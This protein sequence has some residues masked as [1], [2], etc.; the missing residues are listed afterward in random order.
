[1][2]GHLLSCWKTQV[3][4]VVGGW[5]VFHDPSKVLPKFTPNFTIFSRKMKAQTIGIPGTE[6]EPH[7]K[8]VDVK[9]QFFCLQIFVFHSNYNF[10][11]ILEPKNQLKQENIF[12]NGG[13][14]K[15]KKLWALFWFF[16]RNFFFRS[17]IT[18]KLEEIERIW[19][20]ISCR[21]PSWASR[22]TTKSFKKIGLE[23][24][25]LCYICRWN[26][27]RPRRRTR[28]L[29]LSPISLSQSQW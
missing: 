4:P 22:F 11:T 28:V 20:A 1:M 13:K 26:Q 7:P 6:F 25:K 16:A 12:W 23:T 9:N 24:K 14:R 18:R 8:D 17:R 21:G 19:A 3:K 10:S 15:T 29:Y 27:V 5:I 2:L